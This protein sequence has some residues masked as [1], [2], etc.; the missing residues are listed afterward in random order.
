M[1]ESNCNA[2]NIKKLATGDKVGDITFL[3]T[4]IRTNETKA[5]GAGHSPAQGIQPEAGQA[6]QWVGMSVDPQLVVEAA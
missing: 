3:G 1:S 4:E 2:S 6:L 5:P